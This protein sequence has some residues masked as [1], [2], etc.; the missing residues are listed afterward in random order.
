LDDIQPEQT[1][2]K[3]EFQKMRERLSKSQKQMSELLGV[4]LKAIH[5][6]EQGWRRIPGHVER[7]MFFMISRMKENRIY[8]KPCW[9]IKKCPSSRKKQC[10]AWE[11]RAGKLCWHISGT[12]CGGTVQK[13]WT[14][15][16]KICRS[17]EVLT[18][19]IAKPGK[20]EVAKKKMTKTAS[21]T[22]MAVLRNSKEN[23]DI[24]TLKE[25]TRLRGQRLHNAL[26]VLKKQGMVK[27][28]SRGIYVNA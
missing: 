13:N 28:P 26:S 5:S 4:S 7:Q 12:I 3:E 2:E 11:F 8:R 9:V 22:I 16:M 18:S 27:N 21:E 15:K 6:Y 10:P 23:V 19:L 17:C 25:K 20:K 14:E 1:M 24:E